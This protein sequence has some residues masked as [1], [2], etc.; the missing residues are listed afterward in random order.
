MKAESRHRTAFSYQL[1]SSPTEGGDQELWLEEEQPASLLR[2]LCCRGV[3][4]TCSL[5]A[6]NMGSWMS[7]Y[8]RRRALY[9]PGMLS[10]LLKARSW[11]RIIS[12]IMAGLR[13][14]SIVCQREENVEQLG[15]ACTAAE[16]S[17]PRGL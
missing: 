6:L 17:A 9:P 11:F 5:A 16:R 13:A 10:R 2:V 3:L 1:R 8:M 4:H 12:C 15:P 7:V 14:N